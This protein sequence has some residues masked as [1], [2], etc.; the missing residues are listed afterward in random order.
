MSLPRNPETGDV[1]RLAVL[2]PNGWFVPSAVPDADVPYPD[3]FALF[4]TV[5][6]EPTH[7]LEDDL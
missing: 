3:E 7:S 5:A 6:D 2:V 4:S 1:R